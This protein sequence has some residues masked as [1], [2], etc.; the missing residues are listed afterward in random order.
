MYCA[1]WS[2]SLVVL[3][4]FLFVHVFDASGY[5]HRPNK[6]Q[7]LALNDSKKKLKQKVL[8]HCEPLGQG[9][10]HFAMVASSIGTW[11]LECEDFESEIHPDCGQESWHQESSIWWWKTMP[12]C[13]GGATWQ[14][15]FYLVIL[16]IPLLSWRRVKV[17]L[18]LHEPSIGKPGKAI[19]PPGRYPFLGFPRHSPVAALTIGFVSFPGKSG[20]TGSL[21]L[22]AM[23]GEPRADPPVDQKVNHMKTGRFFWIVAL[24][25][26]FFPVHLV[27]FSACMFA[28]PTLPQ[29]ASWE[30]LGRKLREIH[31]YVANTWV[32]Y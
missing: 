18:L 21:Q 13:R 6:P 1:L 14:F 15:S 20:R 17:W 7:V 10:Q 11:A 19:I 2:I 16:V 32:G 8:K 12:G 22:G 31:Q 26:S 5:G 3:V 23:P 30:S 24:N 9:V 25:G 27:H 4:E 28:I 29:R